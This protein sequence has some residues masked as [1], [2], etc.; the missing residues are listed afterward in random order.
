MIKLLLLHDVKEVVESYK[1]QVQAG[2]R[3][4]SLPLATG[5]QN[6]SS[7]LDTQTLLHAETKLSSSSKA[8]GDVMSGIIAVNS[9]GL[10]G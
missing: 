2:L 3:N 1:N 6:A 9:P 5:P 7:L 4:T 10:E 8:M